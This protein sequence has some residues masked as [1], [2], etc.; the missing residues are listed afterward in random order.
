MF[1]V[2]KVSVHFQAC[3]WLFVCFLSSPPFHSLFRS[4]ALV[5]ASH[6]SKL[7]SY[8]W[9]NT[10]WGWWRVLRWSF[11]NQSAVWSLGSI[12][13]HR[14][15]SVEKVAWAMSQGS[16]IYL[17]GVR[18]L[19]KCVYGVSID[20]RMHHYTQIYEYVLSWVLH[21]Y[22]HSQFIGKTWFICQRC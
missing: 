18:A 6:F 21:A 22:M 3:F 19:C 12:S 4:P 20:Q 14:L 10:Q 17:V 5:N 9:Q 1:R 16:T 8:L 7:K 2:Q 13:H 11:I 15:G